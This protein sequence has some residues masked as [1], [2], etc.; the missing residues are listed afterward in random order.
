MNISTPSSNTNAPAPA[1]PASPTLSRFDIFAI[2]VIGGI[3]GGL[4]IPITRSVKLFLPSAIIYAL[5]IVMPFIALGCLWVMATLGRRRASLFQLGKYAAIG[6]FNTALDFGIINL[7]SVMTGINKGIGVGALNSVSFA[8]AVTNS[9][10]WNKY[11]TF[12]ANGSAKSSEF[13]QFVIVSLIGL[14]INS[15]FVTA[16]TTYVAPPGGLDAQQWL[17]AVKAISIVISLLWNFTG[18]KYIVFRNQKP[19]A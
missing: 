10:F 18:Y 12:K 2:L 6:F 5:P 15:G 7:L 1:A 3:F 9:Y 8:I 4:L 14:I 16:L 19:T 11:W 17:N 13:V